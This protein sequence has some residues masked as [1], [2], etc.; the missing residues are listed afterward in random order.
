MQYELR[1]Y[2]CQPGRLPDLCSRFERHTIQLWAKHEIRPIGFWT[3]VLGGS[4]ADLYYMLEWRDMAEREQKWDAFLKD[5][6]WLKVRTETEKNGPLF[7][8]VS[9]SLLTPTSFSK[10]Q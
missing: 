5:P 1:I 10:L 3:V 4:S 8:H 9:N 7:S 6:E 2:H